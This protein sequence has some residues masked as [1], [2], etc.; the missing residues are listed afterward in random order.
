MG[1]GAY[2]ERVTKLGLL[3]GEMSTVD[4]VQ[5]GNSLGGLRYLS[6]LILSD[7]IFSTGLPGYSDTV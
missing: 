3:E 7:N 5:E 6:I 1:E 4:G 2:E